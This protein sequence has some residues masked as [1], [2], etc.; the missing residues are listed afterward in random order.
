[1]EESLL[2][3]GTV[4]LLKGGTKKLMITGFYSK[5]KNNEK[6]YQYNSCIF[7]EGFMD[8]TFCLFDH[9]QIDEIL[10]MGLRSDE[11]NKFVDG[12]NSS[13]NIGTS[14][15]GLMAGQPST[16]KSKHGRVPGAPTNPLSIGEMRSKYGVNKISGENIKSMRKN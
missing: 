15:N 12:R 4:V 8:N 7:P 1:M 14:G 5:S 2:P 3:I 9:S 16:L 13:V 11:H 10:Y 6:I